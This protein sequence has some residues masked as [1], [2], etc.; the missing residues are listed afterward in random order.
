MNRKILTFSV[1]NTPS[2]FHK[3][4]PYHSTQADIHS[5]DC[6]FMSSILIS[7]FQFPEKLVGNLLKKNLILTCCK[8]QG[9]GFERDNILLVKFAILLVWHCFPVLLSNQFWE[10]IVTQI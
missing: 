7:N 4:G 3:I 1:P 6:N 9:K 5:L 10:K 2:P 8:P